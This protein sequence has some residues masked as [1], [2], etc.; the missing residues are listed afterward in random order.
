MGLCNPQMHQPLGLASEVAFI[1]I[2]LYPALCTALPDHTSLAKQ[3]RL[4]MI[5]HPSTRAESTLDRPAC[6]RRDNAPLSYRVPRRR[7]HH[8]Q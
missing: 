4:S 7:F 5:T 6:R 1:V 8:T 2:M 3:C